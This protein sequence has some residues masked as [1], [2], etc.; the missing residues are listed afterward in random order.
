M[1][2]SEVHR[3]M[4]AEKGGRR[5]ERDDSGDERLDST[6]CASTSTLASLRDLES[7]SLQLIEDGDPFD[8]CIDALYEKRCALGHYTLECFPTLSCSLILYASVIKQSV[9]NVVFA[10]FAEQLRGRGPWRGW[11]LCWVFST[12]M[13]AL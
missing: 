10:L 11:S 6:S 9:T 5:R 8:W 1:L 7:S 13:T 3:V 12:F 4:P 2:V